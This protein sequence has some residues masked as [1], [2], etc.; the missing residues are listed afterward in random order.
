MR[1]KLSLITMLLGVLTICTFMLISCGAS[2]QHAF[3]QKVVNGSYLKSTANCLS[4]A[5]YFYSCSCGL[6]GE[7]TFDYG[8]VSFHKDYELIVQKTEQGETRYK[9]C[10]FCERKIEDYSYPK[11]TFVDNE[12]GQ[13]VTLTNCEVGTLIDESIVIPSTYNGKTV[14]KIETGTSYPIF[15]NR[16]NVI[17]VKIPNGVKEIGNRAFIGCEYLKSVEIP[18]SV[19]KIGHSAFASCLSLERLVLTDNVKFIGNRAFQYCDS[20][21]LYCMPESQPDTWEY[22]EVLGSYIVWGYSGNESDITQPT[23][24]Y[25]D[26]IRYQVIENDC[27]SVVVQPKGISGDVVIPSTVTYNGKTYNVTLIKNNAFRECNNLT[28]VYIP[29]SVSIVWVNAFQGCES[30][31]IYCEAT[32]KPAGWHHSWAGTFKHEVVWN[33][34]NNDATEYGIVYTKIGGIRYS[35][36]NGVAIVENQADNLSGV[37]NIPSKIIYKDNEYPVKNIGFGAFDGCEKITSIKIP[38]SVSNIGSK[39][40]R[41]CTGLIGIT[42]PDTVTGI[43][44][45]AFY[46]CSSLK[47]IE[48]PNSVTFIGDYAFSGCSNLKYNIKDGLKYLGNIDNEYLYLAGVQDQSIITATINENCKFIGSEAFKDCNS[49]ESITIPNGVTRIDSN[50][51]ENCSSLKNITI[52]NSVVS[53]GS[54]AFKDCHKLT[55]IKIPNSVIKMGYRA[56]EDCFD[57]TD[58]YCEAE[59]KPSGWSSDWNYSN[60]PVVWG[61]KG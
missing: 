61:Y 1:K 26:G 53:I 21:I 55:S 34:K 19:E 46:G 14:T 20:L 60:L 49:L 41:N 4:C 35:I 36:S 42:I 45:N 7:E 3:D 27:V 29:N 9:K 51:F 25:V 6:A 33:Y 39:A 40:F 54:Y 57:L 47:S 50:S 10:L 32:T 59:S 48:I 56:F 52:P 12:D 31:T 8:E 30:L 37:V 22:L 16:N 24:F 13:T 44:D 2:H 11:F 43:S 58:I 18:D 15:N 28:S 23:S 17:S 5:K 38:E